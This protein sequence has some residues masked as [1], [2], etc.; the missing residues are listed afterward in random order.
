MRL[1]GAVAVVSL[2]ALSACEGETVQV[3]QGCRLSDI[4]EA[5]VTFERP[6]PLEGIT[7]DPASLREELF[8]G[9]LP[10]K[11]GTLRVHEAKETVN[12]AR[13]NLLPSLNAGV[14]LQAST[15]AGF[16]LALVEVAFPFLVPS[17]WF[18][19]F[20]RQE[21]LEAEK[22]AL[23]ILKLNQYASA[24][25]ALS[26]VSVDQELGRLLGETAQ[27]AERMH[28]R[29]KLQHHYGLATLVEVNRAKAEVKKADAAAAGAR[30][31]FEHELA[32][33]RKALGLAPGTA[34]T[35]RSSAPQPV[36]L[37][38]PGLGARI[39]E[40]R[41][42]APEAV[43]LAFLRRATHEGTWSKRF[44]FISGTTLRSPGMG[45][46]GDVSFDDLSTGEGFSLG[47]AIFPAIR[48]SQLREKE[49]AL[50]QLMLEEE[51]G[52]TMELLFHSRQGA[53]ARLAAMEEAEAA[54]GAAYASEVRRHEAGLA[55]LNQVL[56]AL[57]ARR[58]ASVEALAARS[59][60][61]LA[62][63]ALHR[64]LLTDRFAE[65]RGC[66]EPQPAGA[67]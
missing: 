11:A 26:L 47:Y 48:L 4:S 49:V 5:E 17:N 66:E 20:A 30:E 40:A 46:G 64:L 2:L 56:G 61:Q 9:N 44:G 36:E 25:S 52:S 38:E 65:I 62:E 42:N 34:L 13:A 8:S 59:Q 45:A 15:G 53:A 60:L 12:L 19:Y 57:E 21:L 23:W 54:L 6:A 29:V 35:V 41:A 14:L 10:V 67:T 24:Y 32:T 63:I 27:E 3:P 55:D 1:L 51:I 58:R 18:D 28:R 33:L 37:D 22:A 31:L 7:L 50:R 39:I 16:G 43:Q